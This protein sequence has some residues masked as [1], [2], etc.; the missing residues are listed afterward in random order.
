ME[1]NRT[2]FRI[3]HD[4]ASY[5]EL[6][7]NSR[8]QVDSVYV[9]KGEHLQVHY[10]ELDDLHIGNSRTNI[11]IAAFTTCHA[12]L[13]L[14][15]E[16]KKL[17]KRV[18]YFVSLNFSFSSL[19]NQIYILCMKDTDSIFFISKPGQYE[20]KLGNYLGNFTNEIDPVC[21][22]YIDEFVSGGPKNYGYKTN[23]GYTDCTVKGLNFNFLTSLVINYD[24][25]KQIVTEDS[26]RVVRAPQF[27]FK[28][29]HWHVK[30]VIESKLYRYLYDKRIVLPNM[31]TLPYGY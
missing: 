26:S 28:R 5:Q 9:G 11:I 14:F 22:D 18:L 8:F 23:I 3:I 6:L 10:S 20:P 15:E 1:T 27:K 13:Q 29:E 25:I 4:S 7:Q 31:E 19:Y 30:T 16:L 21:G 17:D 24:V 2:H 12:R